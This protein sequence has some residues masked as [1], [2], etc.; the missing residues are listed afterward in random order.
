MIN[1]NTSLWLSR[2]D[3]KEAVMISGADYGAQ[4]TVFEKVDRLLLFTFR[5]GPVETQTVFISSWSFY[6]AHGFFY[7]GRDSR[8]AQRVVL[9]WNK[10]PTH[11]N[12]RGTLRFPVLKITAPQNRRL[13]KTLVQT[14]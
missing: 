9:L 1:D 8:P 5:G 12:C 3:A 2:V 4:T 11:D 14:D 6:G 7:R 13:L 10:H